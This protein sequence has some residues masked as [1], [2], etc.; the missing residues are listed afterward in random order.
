MDSLRKTSIIVGL[1]FV[2]ATASTLLSILGFW[3]I[4]EGDYLNL[5]A[6]NEIPMLI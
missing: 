6:A 1:L 5:V 3:P 2:I 4:Y